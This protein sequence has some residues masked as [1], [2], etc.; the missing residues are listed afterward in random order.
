[1][2]KTSKEEGTTDQKVTLSMGLGATGIE[3]QEK[4]GQESFCASEDLPVKRS[5]FYKKEPDKELIEQLEKMGIK[6]GDPYEDDPIFMPV[7]LPDGWKKRG[8]GHDMHSDVIDDKGR[9]RIGVFYK[10]AFYD[11]R[12]SC[13]IR[14][15]FTIDYTCEKDII[16]AKVLDCEKVVFETEKEPQGARQ[17]HVVVDKHTDACKAWLVTNYPDYEDP[18]KYWDE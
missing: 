5:N 11:R 3:A 18:T 4:R 6:C 7:Q 12:A 2:T 16:G 14:A 10:A 15:R 9:V 17:F 8:T 1:M 13:S